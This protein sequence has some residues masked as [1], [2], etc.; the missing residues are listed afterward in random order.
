MEHTGFRVDR[1]EYCSRNFYSRQIGG[2]GKNCDGIGQLIELTLQ[3]FA[4]FVQKG[5]VK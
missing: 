1:L 3:M 2:D 4:G 5:L